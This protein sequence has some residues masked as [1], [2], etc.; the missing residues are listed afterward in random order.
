[1]ST[2]DLPDNP[3]NDTTNA[4]KPQVK[5]PSEQ[6]ESQIKHDK[7]KDWGP[8]TEIPGT[9]FSPSTNMFWCN[10]HG[11]I[12][13][14]GNMEKHLKAKEHNMGPTGT[15]DLGPQLRTLTEPKTITVYQTPEQMVIED[16]NRDIAEAA[17]MLAKDYE[18]RA[19]YE[20][21]H[22]QFRIPYDWSFY[23]WI[24]ACVVFWNKEWK[25][26]LSLNQNVEALTPDKVSWLKTIYSENL[27]KSQAE[28]I[29]EAP[30]ELTKS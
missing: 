6:T 21:L 2:G 19:E 5:T 28:E 3:N 12:A 17:T 22:Q 8:S 7:V 26:S 23:D 30:P 18:L 29:E 14:S 20:M 16:H 15:A 24:K 11:V 27:A 4:T 9:E 13:N 1:M 25:I 10:F